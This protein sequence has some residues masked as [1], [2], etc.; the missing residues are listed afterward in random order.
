MA[1]YCFVVFLLSPGPD[2]WADIANLK[3]V[4][5]WPLTEIR[6]VFLFSA[7]KAVKEGKAC[8]E[9]V[10]VDDKQSYQVVL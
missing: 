5:L 4:L 7:E 8:H 3:Q 6:C 10:Y 1:S 2:L 9:S